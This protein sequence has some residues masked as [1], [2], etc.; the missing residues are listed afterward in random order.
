MHKTPMN[1]GSL[2]KGNLQA[3]KKYK[4]VSNREGLPLD[5]FNRRLD[6]LFCRTLR[7]MT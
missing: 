7:R 6:I 4:G 5:I 1:K 3:K 2:R